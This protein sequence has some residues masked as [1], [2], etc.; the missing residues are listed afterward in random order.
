MKNSLRLPSTLI[1]FLFLCFNVQA[2]DNNLSPQEVRKGMA[3]WLLA[4]SKAMALARPSQLIAPNLF[5]EGTA[6]ASSQL[7]IE[8]ATR[9]E[10][11]DAFAGLLSNSRTD[12]N[13]QLNLLLNDTI[14][15]TKQLENIG[16]LNGLLAT[17]TS[18]E[19]MF[20]LK[21]PMDWHTNSD[22]S[23]FPAFALETVRKNPRYG[24]VNPYKEGFA[25]VRKDQVYGFLDF[26]G[27]ETITCQ[28][29]NAG[30]FNGGKALVKRVDW[31]FVTPEG[32]ESEAL[33]GVIEAKAIKNGISLVKIKEPKG[34][35]KYAFIDNQYDKSQ[36]P[37]SSFYDQIDEWLDNDLFIVKQGTSVGIIRYDGTIVVKPEHES[38]ENTNAPN[39][40]KI[41][42]GGK[43]GLIGTDGKVLVP[44]IYDELGMFNRFGLAM[45]KKDGKI[46]LL[47]QT[48][49]A[50]SD[51]YKTIA[52]FENDGTTLVAD[53]KGLIGL[54]DKDMDV[55]LKPLFLEITKPMGNGYRAVKNAK[56]LWGYVQKD[57]QEIISPVYQGYSNFTKYGLAV[58]KGY[59]PDC[60]KSERC[61]VDMVIDEKGKVILTASDAEARLMLSDTLL[62]D[63]IV[64]RDLKPSKGSDE[65]ILKG[66]YHLIHQQTLQ[67]LNKTPYD[68]IRGFTRNA[69]LFQV[70]TNQKWGLMDTTGIEIT[71]CIYKEIGV[72]NEGFFPVKD[73]NKKWGFIDR[74]GKVRI[75]FEYK[76]V[77][78]FND[79][80]AL[81][82]KGDSQWGIVNRFNAKVVPC[83]FKSIKHLSLS[84]LELTDEQNRR[85][86]ID[87][88][89]DCIQNC[90]VYEETLR[91]I[92][93][94]EPK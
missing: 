62:N 79:G 64:L 85:F 89:G 22:N 72:E 24:Q 86:E 32:L 66:S 54:I 33:T 48:D 42:S 20:E 47:R 60:G 53:D 93:Q 14:A 2:Q 65:G 46:H 35:Y 81:V 6:T 56:N 28:Y 17:I 21:K 27:H 82:A 70:K 76:E 58:V 41:Q 30:E 19:S 3:Q 12:F 73:E 37:I 63:F 25:S 61:I 69:E 52:F 15:N 34:G 87:N 75:N 77:L 43:K 8:D 83:I 23:K 74:K 67:I 57:G 90:E 92:N 16:L 49:F 55:I 36:Q 11:A 78:G 94:I 51:G 80:L 1:V 29:E 68:A 50:L 59:I 10:S 39:V 9:F 18:A 84:S 45:V 40:Y 38:L 5:K 7:V 31:F 4:K 71:P 91:K 44:P 88:K 26:S 13:K